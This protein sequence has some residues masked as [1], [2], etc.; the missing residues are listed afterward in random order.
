MITRVDNSKGVLNAP[1]EWNRY[2]N[3]TSYPTAEAETINQNVSLHFHPSLKVDRL[4]NVR[5]QGG[6]TECLRQRWL[7]SKSTKGPQH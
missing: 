3:K 6:F 1:L 5:L 2:N 4:P 7:R